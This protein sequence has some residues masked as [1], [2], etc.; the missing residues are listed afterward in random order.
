VV[1]DGRL[2]LG[3][4]PDGRFAL[5]VIDAFGSDAVPVHL[6][7]REALALYLRK[8]SPRGLVAFHLSSSF[9][10]L[11][12]VVAEAAAS[13]GKQGAF[14][15]DDSLTAV[16]AITGKRPSDWAVV[17]ADP[18]ALAPLM[19]SG[20]WVPLASQRRA[21]GGPWLWTDR[22]SSPLAALRRWSGGVR[23]L[24]RT[25]SATP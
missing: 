16:Q 21:T 17:A 2:A 9:F 8:A 19:A 24:S 11:A 10:D 15:H 1:A 22:F 6:L 3:A 23:A 20:P 14:W 25:T 4:Q 12:P 7:T 5:L 18:G 13:L